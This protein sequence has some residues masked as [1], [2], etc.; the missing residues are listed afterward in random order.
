MLRLKVVRAIMN[1]GGSELARSVGID[2]SA[3]WRYEQG[4]LNPNTPRGRKVCNLLGLDPDW[5]FGDWRA[6]T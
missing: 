6:A 1:L 4:V 5:T 2:R 3:L